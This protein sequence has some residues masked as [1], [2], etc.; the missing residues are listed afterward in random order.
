MRLAVTADLHLRES[1]PQRMQNLEALI[2]Q[3]LSAG[4]RRL[5]IAGDLFDSADGSYTRFDALAKAAPKIQ[6]SII[7][8]NHDPDLRQELFTAGNIEI[9][10]TPTLRRIDTRLF[11]LL[12]YR[13][14]STMGEAIA[15][16]PDS[17][18]LRTQSWILISH[19]DF[20]APR[21]A[22]SGR[23]SGYFPLTREDLARFK[24]VKVILGHIHVPNSTSAEVVYPGSPY[25]VTAD[26]YGQRRVLL[27]ETVSAAVAELALAHPPVRIRAEVF[28]IPDG[29][30]QQQIREQLQS[31]LGEQDSPDKLVV[32]VVLKGYSASRPQA[33]TFVES[34]LS[35]QGIACAGIDLESLKV[36]DRENLAAL[37]VAVRRQI[38]ALR[39]E[40][41]E[42]EE[43]RQTV[44][45]KALEIVYGA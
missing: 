33:K 39:L 11:L 42:A 5:L 6:F 2:R 32:Q 13:A 20:A 30:E 25:P 44:L 4:I 8:G 22:D 27:L 15:E 3:L 37:A 17:E 9:I 45:E 12:P 7:P 34:F 36:N 40:Y 19:G 43:L 21:P 24:P 18:Q 38:A 10:R 41:E 35:E 31:A 23:E 14:G 29:R 28:V 1:H 16:L 26:E